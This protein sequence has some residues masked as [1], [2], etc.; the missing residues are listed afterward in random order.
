MMMA[1][2]VD[3]HD[4]I[5]KEML[6]AANFFDELKRDFFADI[7]YFK[8]RSWG[9]SHDYLLAV[10][11]RSTMVRVGTAIFGQRNY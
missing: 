6:T 1:S 5:R 8:E 7:E 9:M 2:N 4:Q 3:D 11:C 10:A